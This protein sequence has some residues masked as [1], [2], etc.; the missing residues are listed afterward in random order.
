S[1]NQVA[2]PAGSSASF[3][4]QT[5]GYPKPSFTESGTLPQGVTFNP[6]NGQL[7]GNLPANAGGVYPISFTA[8]SS[9]GTFTQSFTLKVT[10]GFTSAAETTWTGRGTVRGRFTVRTT[11]LP[12]PTLTASGLPS[13]VTLQDNHDGTAT[14]SGTVRGTANTEVVF[15]FTITA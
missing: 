13:G 15:Q 2:F 14:L 9:L 11:G 5:V 12:I 10:V 3:T 7:S 6:A 8:T 1:P 4:V